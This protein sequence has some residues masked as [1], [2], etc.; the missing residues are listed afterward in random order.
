MGSLTGFLENSRSD[1]FP[2]DGLWL[3][4]ERSGDDS[5]WESLFT[6]SLS[7]YVADSIS[8]I[9][10]VNTLS[11][12][13]VKSGT[14]FVCRAFIAEAD[15]WWYGGCFIPSE[16]NEGFYTIVWR[17]E[18]GTTAGS[19]NDNWSVFDAW[20]AETNN[21]HFNEGLAR[22]R[23]YGWSNG[24]KHSPPYISVLRSGIATWKNKSD[25]SL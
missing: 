4:H 15:A 20:I 23:S 17:I 25:R 2:S 1:E 7:H 5:D 12:T 6:G 24:Y 14:F 11:C 21:A 19:S 10:E 22:I 18:F 3:R 13:A 16:Q 9:F 8:C